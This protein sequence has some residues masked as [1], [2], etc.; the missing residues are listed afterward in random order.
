MLTELC[1]KDSQWRRI[2]L[3]ICRDKMLADDIVQEMYIKLST[4]DKQINDFYVILTMKSIYINYIKNE[5]KFSHDQ[6]SEIKR[7]RQLDDEENYDAYQIFDEHM[8][9]SFEDK[10]FEIRDEYLNVIKQLTWVEKG[11][12]EMN[13]EMS[14]REMAIELNTNY[15]YIHRTIKNA[16]DRLNGKKK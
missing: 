1:K 11:Y 6:Y 14:L 12:L 5:K 4:I 10:E 8:T 9:I 13:I 2:S 7:I 15:A 3:K 16:K